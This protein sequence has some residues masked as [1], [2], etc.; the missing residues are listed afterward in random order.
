MSIDGVSD[1]VGMD[2]VS[3]NKNQCSQ[4]KALIGYSEPW[5]LKFNAEAIPIPHKGRINYRDADRTQCAY[6][7][8]YFSSRSALF[9]HLQSEGVDTRSVDTIFS[10][11]RSRTIKRKREDNNETDDSELIAALNNLD[12]NPAKKTR[13]RSSS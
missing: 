1:M 8:Q 13:K 2:D 5:H 3:T 10:T 12:L 6:C 7:H 11:V 4:E 9:K